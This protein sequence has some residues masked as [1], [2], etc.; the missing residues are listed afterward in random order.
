MVAGRLIH[1]VIR[2]GVVHPTVVRPC[3]LFVSATGRAVAKDALLTAESDPRRAITL[4]NTAIQLAR[5]EQDPTAVSIA[6]RAWG[7]AAHHLKDINLAVRHL[8]R[9]IRFGQQAAVA[10]PAAEARMTL[11][12][13]LSW[14]GHSAAAIKEID[15]ALTGLTGVHRARAEAQR[16][17]IL[18]HMGRFEAAME[19]YRVALPALRRAKDTVWVQRVL[20]NRGIAHCQR[21]EFAA[22]EADM[23]AAQRLCQQQGLELNL[24]LVHHNLAFL[25][26]CRGDVPAAI[27]YLDRAESCFRLLESQ[28]GQLLKDRASLL[29]SA[30]LFAEARQAAEEA[31]SAFQREGRGLALPE[32][33]LLLSQAALLDGDLPAARQQASQALREFT[34][35]QRDEWAAL[36]QLALISCRLRDERLRRR[37]RISELEQVL[38]VLAKT[39]PAAAAEAGLAAARLALERGQHQR[40]HDLLRRVSR[41]RRHGVATLRARAWYAEAL[42]RQTA[43]NRRGAASA[44]RAGL[45]ILDEHVAGLG[46]TDLRA[47]AAGHR[48]DLAELGL[49]LAKQDQSLPRMFQ[50]AELGRA[51][52][53]SYP[54]ARPP[55]DPLL[56]QALADLRTTAAQIDRLR[57]RSNA[58]NARLRQRQLALERQIRDH[59]RRKH[60]DP[61]A[62]PSTPSIA[63]LTE[64]LGNAVLLEYLQLDSTLHVLVIADGRVRLREVGPV[65]ELGD[66]VDIVP[67]ALRRLIRHN[68]RRGS[69]VAADAMLRNTTSQLD[70]ALFGPVPEIENRPLVI[71]PTGR[72]QSLAWPILPSCWGRPVTV[73]PSATLWWAARGRQSSIGSVAVAAGPG[74]AGAHDEA[75]A[76]AAIHGTT[77]L[78]GEAATVAAVASALR[79]AALAHLATHGHVYP[80]NPLFSKLRFA[81]GPLMVHDI[82]AIDR[83]PHTVVLAACDSG[84]PIV[85]SG[86]EVLGLGAALLAQGASQLVAPLFSVRDTETA[87]LMIAFHRQLAAGQPVANAL[88]TAQQEI[89]DNYP[90]GLTDAAPFVCLGAGF[91]VP[92]L[93]PRK[94][95]AMASV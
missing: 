34:H 58:G 63:T 66:L 6:E 71:I 9:A 88:A 53:L 3:L 60:S 77:A 31:V 17:A 69:R 20:Q 14:R 25:H 33:R 7:L 84:R 93:L 8:R 19:N 49:R 21:G 5:T 81:D 27:S 62:L 18:Y 39:W 82:E 44:A 29:L 64:A 70:N 68:V 74:L 50:W 92:N 94:Q 43:G 76:I 65:S 72:L 51:R 75:A 52:Y 78:I 85:R 37:V 83:V 40:G 55:D 41:S 79:G 42:W 16:G 24:G 35:H 45:R 56:A 2:K 38:A 59:Y 32:A 15:A 48:T 36:A 12:G 61:S 22:A 67:F 47:H 4:A 86:D 95:P 46:A 87:P 13:V 73:A 91:T 26:T 28:L 1:R 80:D 23:R 10:L 30:R 89:A 57:G 54:P 90:S 11:A